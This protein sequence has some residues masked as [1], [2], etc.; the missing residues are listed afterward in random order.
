MVEN[1]RKS[2]AGQILSNANEGS[3]SPPL[4]TIEPHEPHNVIFVVVSFDSSVQLLKPFSICFNLRPDLPRADAKYP[5]AGI[6]YLYNLLPFP[7]TF[8][9]TRNDLYLLFRSSTKDVLFLQE[10]NSSTPTVICGEISRPGIY[11]AIIFGTKLSFYSLP[12][13]AF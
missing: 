5:N 10:A 11:F 12:S 6:G 4:F 7:S 8:Y 9:D 1:S 13:S 2:V 3:L